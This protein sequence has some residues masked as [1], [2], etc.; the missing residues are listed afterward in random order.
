MGDLQMTTGSA[1]SPQEASPYSWAIHA[2]SF[3]VWVSICSVAPEF[4]WQGWQVNLHRLDWAGIGSVVL[5]GGIVAFFVEPLT[6]RLR[7]LRLHL[8]HERRTTTHATLAAFGVAVLA[9]L[10]HEAIAAFIEHPK[11]GYSEKDTIFYAISE[12]IQWAWIPFTVTLAWLSARQA[13][14]FRGVMLFVAFASNVMSGPVFGWTAAV[15]F[16]TAVPC[17]AILFCGYFVMQRKQGHA[18]FQRCAA[19]AAGIAIVWLVA[20]GILQLALSSVS[21]GG[22]VIYTWS[23]YAIDFRFYVGWVIGL[24][25]APRPPNF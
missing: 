19:I 5:T 6:E 21:P 14:W 23:E 16:T 20:M 17:A 10:V 1:N 15:S 22:I 7:S 8:S 9:V 13:P 18:A 2:V 11:P 3:A 12:V 4:I 24:A 25:V